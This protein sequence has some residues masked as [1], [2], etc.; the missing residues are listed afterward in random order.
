MDRRSLVVALALLMFAAWYGIETAK[1]PKRTL[2]Y[3]PDPAFFPWVL[4]IVLALLALMLLIAGLRAKDGTKLL[5]TDRAHLR[6]PLIALSGFLLFLLLLPKLGFLGAGVPFFIGLMLLAG[7]RRI[8]WLVGAG[9]SG[10]LLLFML[11]H[12]IF[13]IL[14]PR[15]MWF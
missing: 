11:F 12:H 7:E 13:H 9:V 14:L 3:S 10:P 1:L 8:W 5:P 2:P 4:V 15:G 6:Y